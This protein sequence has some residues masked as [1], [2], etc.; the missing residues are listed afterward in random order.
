MALTAPL[1]L[2]VACAL[3]A[4]TPP[5]PAALALQAAL[6]AAVASGASS[7]GLPAGDV[8]FNDASF[9]ITNASAIDIF[10]GVGTTLWFGPGF[11]VAVANSTN[12]TLRDFVIDYSPLPYVHGV[13]TAQSASTITVSLS[14]TSMTFETLASDYPPHDT[15]PPVSVFDSRT[16]DLVGSVCSWGV[17]APA[18][19]ISPGVYSIAC[20]PGGAKLGDVLVA[21][22]RVG[23]TL[24]LSRTAEMVTRNVTLHAAS[25]MAITEFL[26]DG[27]NTYDH[28]AV[29]PRNASTPLGSNADGFHSSGMRRGPQLVGVSIHNLLDGEAG[30]NAGTWRR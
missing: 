16:S 28:V 4:A 23:L 20:R 11:G 19:R 22:T 18:T 21:A 8:F 1:H 2:L 29:V 25:Y 5:S 12:S 14:P 3:A 26:G 24:S 10:G 7:F 17:P 9:N 6:D 27:G 15:W 13:I 30:W